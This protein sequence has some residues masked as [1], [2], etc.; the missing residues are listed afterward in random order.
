MEPK[1]KHCRQTVCQFIHSSLKAAIAILAIWF[2]LS[3]TILADTFDVKNIR[4]A[5]NGQVTRVVLDT[6]AIPSYK[7]FTLNNPARLVIDLKDAKLATRVNQAVFDASFVEKLRFAHRKNNKLRIVLDLNQKIIPKSFVLPPNGNSQH[8]LVIDLK[9]AGKSVTQVASV[10]NKKDNKPKASQSVKKATDKKPSTAVAST[11]K[12]TKTVETKP[13]KQEDII[14]KITTPKKTKVA[15]TKP[16]KQADAIAKIITPKPAET[17]SKPTPALTKSKVKP[18]K[19]TLI[20]AIDPGHG[21]KD[22]G[23]T[24]YAGTRE[25]DVVLQISQRLKRLINA[26][27]G[28]RAIMTRDSDKFLTLRGRIK[29]AREQKADI[30]ISI[31]ADAVNDRRVRGSSVYVLSKNG[32]SSEAARFLAKTQNESDVIGGVKLQ[33]KGKDVQKVLVDLSQAATIDAS[34]KLATSVKN[35]LSRLGK[36]RKNVEHAGFAVLKSP[37][38]PSILVET[39]FISNASEEKKLRSA[40]HQQKL[41][42]SMF[43]GL[44]GYLKHHAPKDTILASNTKKTPHTIK[45]GETLSEIAVR[46]RVS[47][48]SIRKTNSL[49][50]DRIRVGQKLIIPGV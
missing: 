31:H 25:K 45:Y 15:E 16:A 22:P 30:F 40:T 50:T 26:E 33:G 9:H 38:I 6:N 35:E 29:K 7:M 10:A 11:P 8:R 46:Y 2:G 17:K 23:A 36:T 47:V 39:A 42:V 4:V 13:A 32:A 20:I 49:S 28:M 5:K 44:K 12:K 19:Q 27:K 41:A 18:A 21:G 34:M 43:K 48:D 24:G 37:D 1:I 3:P 14:A